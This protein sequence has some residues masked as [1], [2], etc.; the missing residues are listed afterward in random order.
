MIRL[1]TLIN[2]MNFFY[3]ENFLENFV[4][5]SNSSEFNAWKVTKRVHA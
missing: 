4:T 1:H 5:S 3:T 2:N